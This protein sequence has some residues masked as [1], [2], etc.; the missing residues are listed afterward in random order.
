MIN[1]IF[2]ILNKYINTEYKKFNIFIIWLILYFTNQLTWI[3]IKY[4]IIIIIIIIIYKIIWIIV[5]KII[6]KNINIK[7]Y[8]LHIMFQIS[9]KSNIILYGII[10]LEKSIY[11]WKLKKFIIKILLSLFIPLKLFIY[12]IYQISYR[13]KKYTIY[14]IIVK[15]AFGLILSVLIFTNIIQILIIEYIKEWIW[16]NPNT[17][18]LEYI[19]ENK[20]IKNKK[21]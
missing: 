14:E 10:C 3:R 16:N 20:K 15:R 12:Y 9:T 17:S 8:W 21:H 6:E 2:E 13:L 5:E 18:I 19:Q 1:K 11:K 4:F 7:D